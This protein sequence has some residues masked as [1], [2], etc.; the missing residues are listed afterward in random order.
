MFLDYV[1]DG[2]HAT[3]FAYGQ[4]GSGK[5]YTMEGFVYHAGGKGPA[6]KPSLTEPQRL[7]LVPR[8][9][10]GLF[11]RMERQSLQGDSSFT[12]RLSFLQIY[13]EPP[14]LKSA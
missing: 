14:C 2:Y 13:N 12:F 5:T 11:E 3:I 4:T 8:A 6:A 1:L 9:V 7:G 10:E